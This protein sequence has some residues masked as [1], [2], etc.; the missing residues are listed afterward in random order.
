MN[1]P[2]SRRM[3]VT[4]AAATL[5]LSAM[6][7]LSAATDPHLGWARET[8]AIYSRIPSVP[9]DENGWAAVHRITVEADVYEEMIAETPARTLAGV[10]EQLRCGLRYS[11]M[12]RDAGIAA[13]A[14][15]NALAALTN[16]TNRTV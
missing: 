3:A 11:G 5:G 8:E 15:R 10:V 12:D 16:L 7:T 2:T 6:P 13:A 9:N 4:G 1:R 14:F